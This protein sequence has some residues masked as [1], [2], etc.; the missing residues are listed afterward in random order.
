LLVSLT[1]VYGV[2]AEDATAAV[3]SADST[4]QVAFV[5]VS[6]AER[7]GANVSGLIARLNEA[8]SALTSAR[9][10]LDAGN[11]SGAASLAA[12]SE[13]LA[14]AVAADAAVSKDNAVTQASHWWVTVSLSL[15]GS[16][17][18]LAVLFLLWRRFKRLYKDRVLGGRPEVVE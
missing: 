6:D 12:L 8:G 4:L 14:D 18:L 11:Y 1:R 10:A 5:T 2:S 15:V 3:A 7:A 16:A 9:V 13:G 17:S